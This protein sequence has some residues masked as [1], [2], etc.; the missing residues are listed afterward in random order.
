MITTAKEAREMEARVKR[1][2]KAIRPGDT[3]K[4]VLPE[5]KGSINMQKKIVGGARGH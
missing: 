1:V 2:V 4:V 3:S 5:K